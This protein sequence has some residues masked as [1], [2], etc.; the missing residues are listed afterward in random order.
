MQISKISILLKKI[1]LE[2]EKAANP[3]LQEFGLTTAQYKILK[4]LYMHKDK[5][6]R[7]VDIERY[8]SLTHPTAIGLLDQLEK[9]EFVSRTANPEDARSKLIILNGKAIEHEKRLVAVGD[10]M[11]NMLTADLTAEEQAQLF[12]TLEKVLMTLDREVKN[13]NHNNRGTHRQ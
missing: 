12:S 11:E 9:K 2:F 10:D 8:Y 13:E 4:Y 3:M 7:L 6:V 5:P 1:L